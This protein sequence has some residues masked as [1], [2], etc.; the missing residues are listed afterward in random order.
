VDDEAIDG[1]V[2][3]VWR[4]AVADLMRGDWRARRWI[5]TRSFDTWVYLFDP[6]LDPEA[7]RAALLRACDGV[8]RPRRQRRRMA[9]AASPLAPD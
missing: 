3:A 9:L 1:L 5:A 8:G 2:I 7:V 6:Q 4:Q